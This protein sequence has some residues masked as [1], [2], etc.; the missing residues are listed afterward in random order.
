M[1]LNLA[2]ISREGA[3]RYGDRAALVAGN[4]TLSYR[5]LDDQAQRLAGALGA[6]CRVGSTWR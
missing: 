4:T 2:V 3:K 5:Q 6:S 1:S